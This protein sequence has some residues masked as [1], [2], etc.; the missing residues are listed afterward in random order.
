MLCNPIWGQ[1]PAG[2]Q[3]T[4]IRM[5]EKLLAPIAQLDRAA[6]F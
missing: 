2:L 3:P 1:L 4:S 6:D 5:L